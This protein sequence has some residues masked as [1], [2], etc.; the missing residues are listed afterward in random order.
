L[1]VRDLFKSQS[2]FLKLIDVSQ[3]LS[4][5][6]RDDMTKTLA[7]ALHAEVSD[8]ISS[9]AY[10]SHRI[11]KI[12]PDKDKVL[13]ESVDIIRYAIAIMNI[14][15][16]DPTQFESAWLSKDRYLSTSRIL[17]KN[18]WQGEKVAIIDIDDVICEFREG[19]SA[20]LKKEYGINTDVKST[21]YYFINELE[22]AGV[23]PE[24]VFENFISQ[25]GFLS[26]SPVDGAISFLESLRENDYF[27]HL[28]TARAKENLRCYYNTLEWLSINS[29][30]FDKIDFS[31]E[32]LRWC[33]KSEYWT[34][35]AIDFAIDDS[36]KHVA[37]YAK[38][39]IEVLVPN[40]PY[41]S[42]VHDYQTVRVY[43]N[44]S[45]IF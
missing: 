7:L 43:E 29:I 19:F 3:S 11:E 20:W 27:I 41:N 14:W 5:D 17:E 32:K 8:L 22:T 39:G 34:S 40:K 35:G 21:E 38:H 33:M 28:L 15:N 16:I 45:E 12:K 13:F 30:P 1:N 2:D 36:P 42:E 18:K 4:D 25:G 23:N 26:L 24:G 31:S 44:I 6:E 37:E 9:T 10:K